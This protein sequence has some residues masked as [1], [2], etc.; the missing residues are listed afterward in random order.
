MFVFT[1]AAGKV[2]SLLPCRRCTEIRLRTFANF[3]LCRSEGFQ[4]ARLTD[5][6][7]R[8][9]LILSCLSPHEDA[10]PAKS[11]R[12]ALSESRKAPLETYGPCGKSSLFTSARILLAAEGEVQPNQI[13]E[14]NLL[15]ILKRPTRSHRDCEKADLYE[16]WPGVLLYC[17]RKGLSPF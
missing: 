8:G 9:S 16:I 7:R 15:A 2:Y 6:H 17:I 14:A 13:K 4:E 12:Q 3:C 10:N 1:L 5:L 11:K